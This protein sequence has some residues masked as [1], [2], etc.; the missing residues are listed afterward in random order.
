M[1]FHCSLVIQIVARCVIAMPITELQCT[2]HV[3]LMEGADT[4]GITNRITSTYIGV[5]STHVYLEHQCGPLYL[6]KVNITT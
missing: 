5:L 2:N 1:T 4:T 3:L 6:E